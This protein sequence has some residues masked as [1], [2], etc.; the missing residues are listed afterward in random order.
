MRE[1]IKIHNLNT[2]IDMKFFISSFF[3]NKAAQIVSSQSKEVKKKL[4]YP[5]VRL[6][7][8]NKNKEKK[9]RY[10]KLN[11]DLCFNQR[12]RHDKNGEKYY[13]FFHTKR[14]SIIEIKPEFSSLDPDI[15]ELLQKSFREWPK[16]MTIKKEKYDSYFTKLE[17]YI[18]F[19]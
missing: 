19:P 13:D 16:H 3:T 18:I 5:F 14:W 8:A 2:E 4:Q 12:L 15:K 9:G 7:D 11:D 1:F 10:L 17:E 6:L